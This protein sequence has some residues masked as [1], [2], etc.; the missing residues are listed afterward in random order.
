[1]EAFYKLAYDISCYYA[2]AA[3]FL[4]YIA[5]YRVNPL[6]V[7]VFFAAC[8]AAVHAEHIKKY[9]YSQ[10]VRIGAFV[11]PVIPFI[12]ETDI[13]GKLILILPWV[14]M[15]V[16]V[17]RE[18]YDVSY[19]RFRKTFICFFWIFTVVFCFFIAEDF[20]K[21]EVAMMV[22]GPFL[23]LLLGA[24]IFLL[25]ML[26]FQA[27]SGDKKQLEK[28]QRKQMV[29]F[30]IAAI[31]FTLG[32][33]VEMLYMYVFY[34]LIKLV[35]GAVFALIVF[36]VGKLDNPPE[37]AKELG[38]K[39]DFEEYAEQLREAQAKIESIYG[40]IRERMQAY[41]P[42]PKEMD[43]M[44]VIIIVSVLAAIIILAVL[45]GGKRIMRKQAAIEDE[46]E[47]CYD[48][49]T[50]GEVIKKRSVRPE[51]VIRYYYREFMKKS[52]A[53]KHKL[54]A[55]DTTKEILSKYEAWNDATAK[56]SADAEEATVLYQ[57][58]R[59]GKAKMTRTDAARMKALVKGL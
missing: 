34:P 50:V 6:S 45:F 51:I 57:K 54:K 9:S 48:E 23:V 33:V 36:I 21:G 18:G 4:S 38:N 2:F 26:R 15:V 3:F 28:Y 19:R 25:Q 7:L 32:N 43:Y 16:T 5:E 55:S 52:E 53:K 14:Y 24:G 47:D 27:G 17:L 13:W 11:L 49:V 35:L 31:V 42:N 41:D 56:Q 37:V 59:Y 12:L 30:L 1:M 44:P 40:P 46:R 20:T 22:A 8:F 58:T 10:A 29:I 39:G